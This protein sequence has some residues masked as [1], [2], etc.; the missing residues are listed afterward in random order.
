MTVDS[1]I[2]IGIPS[3]GKNSSLIRVINLSLQ[4]DGVLEILVSINPTM[5]VEEVDVTLPVD[6]R[7]QYFYQLTD[8]GLYGNFHYLLKKAK[9]S[10]FSWV[11]TDDAP[12]SEIGN[13][14]ELAIK[15][16]SNLIIPTWVRQE[17]HPAVP[18]H[19]GAVE[20]GQ[21]PGL[22]K[23]EWKLRD[24]INADPS[25]IFGLWNKEFLLRIFPKRYFDGLDCH[26]LQRVLLT[27]K[28]AKYETTKPLIIG[29]WNWAS[30]LPARVKSDRFNPWRA[31]L[32]NLFCSLYYA[33]YG[34]K[35]FIRSLLRINT[36]LIQYSELNRRLKG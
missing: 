14:L 25:W 31:I 33:R 2:T 19:V 12:V 32:W 10:H 18:G 28:I 11:C 4:L 22:N 26:L 29:T 30:K 5:T 21:L 27:G 16:D 35:P 15:V 7:I 3:R 8:L 23:K 9:G 36:L 13:M 17:Y 1:G 24:S 34:L 20:I 6:D